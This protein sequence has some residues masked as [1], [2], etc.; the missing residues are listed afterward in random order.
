MTYLTKSTTSACLAVFGIGIALIVANGSPVASAQPVDPNAGKD[1]ATIR[2]ETYQRG[3]KQAKQEQERIKQMD[4]LVSVILA[5]GRNQSEVGQRLIGEVVLNRV[6]SPRYPN[7]VCEVVYQ[8]KQF[9]AFNKRK[10]KS[11]QANYDAVQAI[12]SG[13]SPQMLKAIKTAKTVMDSDK[14]IFENNV[15]YYHTQSVNPK[16]SKSS[17]LKK[18]ATIDSHIAYK[19]M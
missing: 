7:T 2:Y 19:R 11:M 16:W 14:D 8:R 17:K 15:M 5:E 9:S 10:S 4:C 6:A 13:T 12:M 1:E 3:L 18:V